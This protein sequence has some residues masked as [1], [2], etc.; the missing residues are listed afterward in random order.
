VSFASLPEA[1][2]CQAGD[3]RRQRHRRRRRSL[4]ER[5]VKG[6][7][8]H[9]RRSRLNQFLAAIADIDAPQA[10]HAIEDAVA[11]T[12]VDIAALGM[13]DDPATAELFDFGPVGLRG[14]MVRDVEAAQFG[15][16]VIAGHG[17]LL[18]LRAAQGSEMTGKI[19]VDQGEKQSRA[20]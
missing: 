16:V 18:I 8:A 2:A 3:L 14:K 5:V 4:E 19:P 17:K 20:R 7:L 6:Q 15:D 10:G 1:F 12:V 11:V 13:R 9:L